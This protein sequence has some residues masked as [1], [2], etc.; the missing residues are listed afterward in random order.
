MAN[1]VVL[2]AA[3]RE[4]KIFQ[5]EAPF[6]LPIGQ[7]D[8]RFRSLPRGA[9]TECWGSRS[10]G[11]TALIHAILAA[12]TALG[13]TCA[14]V[15]SIDSF[16]PVSAAA[17]GVDLDRILWVRCH[18]RPDHAMKVADWILHAGGFGVVVLDLCEIAPAV[19]RRIPLSW[20]YRYRN[21]IEN[22]RTVFVV[23]ADQHLA[24]PSAAR[25]LATDCARPIWSG[26]NLDPLLAGIEITF[27]SRKP[28]IAEPA[29]SEA[30][31][32][33]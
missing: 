23:A 2:G 13:E 8:P 21:V 30:R 29:R 10:S 33:G 14:V 15:D 3:L 16:D 12:S 26:S 20:W 1:K 7:L 32:E 9:I 22:T 11:R 25:V 19:L 24:G 27:S 28:S 4:E 17:N 18:G 5:V 6:V 31:L